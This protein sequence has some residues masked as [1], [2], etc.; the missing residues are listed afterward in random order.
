MERSTVKKLTVLGA[1][2]VTVTL[3]GSLAMSTNPGGDADESLVGLERRDPRDYEVVGD[4]LSVES[5][6]VV[7]SAG[8]QSGETLIP[9]SRVCVL[10]GEGFF[11]TA[12]GPFVHLGGEPCEFVILVSERE[13][14]A[15]VP[16]ELSGEVS[17]E[18]INP[19]G[20]RF[21]GSVDLGR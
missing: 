17:V 11:G 3:L 7:D 18:I 1:G 9:S 14:R 2:M 15:S 12:V 6:E 19:D 4:G 20:R 13:I 10:R 8:F 5:I 21:Q 16:E